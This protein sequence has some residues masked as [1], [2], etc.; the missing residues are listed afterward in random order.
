MVGQKVLVTGGSGY[1]GSRICLHLANQGYAV[2]AL[3]HSKIPPDESWVKKMD[4][5]LIGDVRDE[6]FVLKVANY[7]YD[8]LVHLISLDHRQSNANPIFVSSVNITPVWFLLNT[9]S[10][11]GLKKFIYLST[12]QVYGILQDKVIMESEPLLSQTPY[13]LTHQI[14]ELICEYYNRISDVNCH[15]VRLSNSYGAPI[16]KENN[17]WWLV[18]NDLCRMAYNEKQI[19]LQSDGSPL[20]D[21]IH[22]WDVSSGVQAIIESKEKHSVYNLSSG[23]TLSILEIAKIIKKVFLQRYGLELAIEVTKSIS[24]DSSSKTT[25]YEIDNSLI[26]SI[27]FRPKWSLEEG[28]SDLFDYLQKEN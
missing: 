19:V 10:K 22:G 18:V 9:F 25:P 4:K 28:I 12:A 8:V 6:Q 13:G 14:G 20:R 23:I 26:C 3:C 21:F 7:D 5:V 24:K 2:T 1:I 27:G 11:R 15:I 17:C 16:L